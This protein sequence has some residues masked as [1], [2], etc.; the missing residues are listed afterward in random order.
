MAYDIN[1][2]DSY[3]SF[4]AYL[5]ELYPLRPLLEEG[6]IDSDDATILT[7]RDG[8]VKPFMVT[9]ASNPVKSGATSFSGTRLDQRKGGMDVVVVARSGAEARLV[10]NDVYNQVIGFKP[11]R[12]G[13]VTDA[14]R[15]LWSDAR[16]MDMGNRPTRWAVSLSF[17]WG[18]YHEKV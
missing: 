14:D 3:A 8:T 11:A 12:S 2:G 10:A 17:Q 6:T 5:R 16:G 4:N 13:R 18:L 1:P 15:G 7:Y 9:W